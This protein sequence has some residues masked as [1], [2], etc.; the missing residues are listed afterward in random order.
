MAGLIELTD[1]FG[2]VVQANDVGTVA[3][4][5]KLLV[6]AAPFTIDAGIKNEVGLSVDELAKI[7]IAAD[8]IFVWVKLAQ[9]LGDFGADAVGGKDGEQQVAAKVVGDGRFAGANHAG[10][11]DEKGSV[12]GEIISLMN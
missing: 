11:G 2:G 6:V 4:L 12:H 5:G 9:V 8:N 10:K 1:F 3:R 7:F